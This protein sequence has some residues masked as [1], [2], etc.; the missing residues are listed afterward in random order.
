MKQTSLIQGVKILLED[1]LTCYKISSNFI[2]Q[3]ENTAHY[4]FHLYSHNFYFFYT[5]GKNGERETL[6]SLMQ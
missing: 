6:F 2:Q 5:F 1:F 4:A 3:I